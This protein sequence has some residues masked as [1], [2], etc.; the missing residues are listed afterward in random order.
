MKAWDHPKA[1][2]IRYS[3]VPA[4]KDVLMTDGCSAPGSIF[5]GPAGIHPF[6]PIIFPSKTEHYAIIKETGEEMEKAGLI[7]AV[8]PQNYPLSKNP[9]DQSQRK[10]EEEFRLEEQADKMKALV[11]AFQETN[12]EQRAA[13]AGAATMRGRQQ[14]YVTLTLSP[15]DRNA[16]M[17]ALGCAANRHAGN[18]LSTQFRDLVARINGY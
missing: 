9:F 14:G 3:F 6:E 10:A 15:E 1:Q 5:V 4:M 16:L 18:F 12:N 11:E 7:G 13:Q 17:F 2:D 8:C